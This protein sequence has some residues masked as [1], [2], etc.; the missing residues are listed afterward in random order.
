MRRTG[1][2]SA[3]S[4]YA[5][6]T[7]AAALVIAVSIGSML[8]VDAPRPAS[9]A[10]VCPAPQPMTP[11]RWQQLR[12]LD[13][14]RALR[15]MVTVV[16]SGDEIRP[17]RQIH[18][19]LCPLLD[20]G[21]EGSA[22]SLGFIRYDDDRYGGMADAEEAVLISKADSG[23][24]IRFESFVLLTAFFDGDVIDV[25]GTVGGPARIVEWDA[26][27][28]GDARISGAAVEGE[29]LTGSLTGEW[30][31]QRVEY[32]WLRNGG[33]IAG[34]TS[35]SYR[36]QAADRGARV[37]L[38]VVASSPGFASIAREARISAPVL[39]RITDPGIY[40]SGP[41]LA[42]CAGTCTAKHTVKTK[43]KTNAGSVSYQWYLNKKKVK[44][45]TKRSYTLRYKKP[46]TGVKSYCVSVRV[47]LR[48]AGFKTLT[49]DKMYGCWRA[50][51]RRS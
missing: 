21:T 41:R 10:T 47:T 25:S 11:Q 36:L 42:R 50:T 3:G 1:W 2:Q 48:R 30:Y 26:V 46:R 29:T 18:P 16:V 17:G 49:V 34:A 12:S 4:A 45:Q 8:V 38:R 40:I 44:G 13:G 14:E 24:R 51:Y 31:A 28:A 37:S 15:E 43:R 5:K 20:L 9:A 33:P 23:K 22:T 6:R 35:P 7:C 32:Q 19:R 39:G 27:E